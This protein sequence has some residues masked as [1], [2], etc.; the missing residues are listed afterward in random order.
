MISAALRFSHTMFTEGFHRILKVMT[1]LIV[2]LVGCFAAS[3]YV[4][5]EISFKETMLWHYAVNAVDMIGFVSILLLVPMALYLLYRFLRDMSTCLGLRQYEMTPAY[6]Y[7]RIREDAPLVGILGTV[8]GMI[9]ASTSLDVGNGLQEAINNLVLS[10][11]HAGIT[12]VAGIC[13]VLFIQWVVPL[14]NSNWFETL[15][16]EAGKP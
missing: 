9:E 3:I 16:K 6:T 2:M 4:S 7:H 5:S 13:L 1:Y 12:T 10:I 11:G 15:R 14:V 8:C